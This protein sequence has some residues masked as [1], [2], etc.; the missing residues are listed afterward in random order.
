V[1]NSISTLHR[2]LLLA[3]P[4][5]LLAVGSSG[6]LLAAQ[7]LRPVAA[8][9]DTARR[10]RAGDLSRR[11]AL[12]G[13]RDELRRLADT[14]DAMIASLEQLVS[15]QRQFLADASHELRTPLTVIC[16]ALETR[17][18]AREPDAACLRETLQVVHTEARRMHRLV[19]DLLTLARADSGQLPLQLAPVQL[20][21]VVKEACE[22]AEWMLERRR[23]RL[24]LQ[25]DVTLTADAGRLRQLMLNLLANAAQHTPPHGEVHVVLQRGDGQA[26]LTVRDNGEG[27]APEHLPH[28]FERFYRADGA[29]S[30][31]QGG[32]GLG[33]AIGHWI[34]EAHGGTLVAASELGRGSTFTCSLPL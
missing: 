33:L 21:E 22:A 13:P 15:A 25:E 26:I 1:E 5:L 28:V 7:A 29:R 30:P 32:T 8:I 34:A 20:E 18:R 6:Y 12:A 24:D 17:L 16:T 3:L 10:I 9:T 23:L 11:I 31:R 27:I 19:E 2:L 4:L 14:F